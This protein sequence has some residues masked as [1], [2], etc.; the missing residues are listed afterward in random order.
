MNKG[1]FDAFRQ[2]FADLITGLLFTAVIVCV[3][4]ST[5]AMGLERTAIYA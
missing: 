4:G 5:V 2:G 3:V 1:K